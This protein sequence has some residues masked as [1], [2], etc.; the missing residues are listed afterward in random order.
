MSD[1]SGFTL[2]GNFDGEVWL[3]HEGCDWD[4]V[5]SGLYGKATLTDALAAAQRHIAEHDGTGST[6]VTGCSARC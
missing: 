1:L 4:V 5:L 3:A 2:G 6:D